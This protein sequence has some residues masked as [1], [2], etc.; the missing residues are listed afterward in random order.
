MATHARRAVALTALIA[1]FIAGWLAF[2]N[3]AGLVVFASLGV[4]AVA[5]AISVLAGR[6]GTSRLNRA[7]RALAD[8]FWG[9]G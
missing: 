1:A 6:T 8:A 4:V 5:L 2:P 3:E 7:C 9:I